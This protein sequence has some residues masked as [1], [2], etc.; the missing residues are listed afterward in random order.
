MEDG[1]HAEY[2]EGSIPLGFNNFSLGPAIKKQPESGMGERFEAFVIPKQC[3]TMKIITKEE[4]E[5]AL[6][7]LQQKPL[8]Q[9]SKS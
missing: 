4:K 6:Q 3:P 8:R 1:Y 9:G 2:L 7:S 5:N